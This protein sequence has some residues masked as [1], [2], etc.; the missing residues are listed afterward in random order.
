MNDTDQT[1]HLALA[2][3]RNFIIP[4]HVL[5]V[6][7]FANNSKYQ[8]IL[9]VVAEDLEEKERADIVLFVEKNNANI[10][11]YSIEKNVVRQFILLTDAPHVT[12]ATYYRLYIPELVPGDINRL[13]Y[14][15][16]DTIVNGE[17]GALYK[18]LLGPY[19][20]AAVSDSKILT[21]PDLGI[22]KNGG[23]FNAGVLLIN[24]KEW[25]RQRISEKTIEYLNDFSDK[26]VLGDQDALN[27]VL[28]NNWYKLCRGYNVT[29]YDIPNRLK[30]QNFEAYLN[31]KVIIHY[32][33]QNKPWLL[34][35]T[36]RLRYLYRYYF[37]RSPYGSSCFYADEKL[38]KKYRY[39]IFK[40]WLKEFLIDLGIL[41]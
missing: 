1:I 15:D 37:Q 28:A 17:L 34:T 4:F 14:L 13:L 35:C 7:I 41:T 33:T 19:P 3:D 36:N 18:T 38:R 32:T 9:H 20:V 25:K 2:F 22:H 8:V 12:A 23:Y 5:L 11:F 16:T 30:R 26:L 24:L 31:E 6:S 21:R 27:F 40:R 29:F 39:K 10:Y